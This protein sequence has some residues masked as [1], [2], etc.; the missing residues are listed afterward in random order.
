M[1]SSYSILCTVLRNKNQFHSF[2]FLRV[3]FLAFKLA[4]LQSSVHW[5]IGDAAY[6]IHTQQG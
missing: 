3:H 6:S 5:I 4:K 1:I 2:K